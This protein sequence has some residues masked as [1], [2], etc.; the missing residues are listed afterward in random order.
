MASEIKQFAT[1]LK[2]LPRELTRDGTIAETIGDEFC[3]ELA[4]R[5]PSGL[6]ITKGGGNDEPSRVDFRKTQRSVTPFWTGNQVY[7]LEYGTGSPAVGKYP[8]SERMLESNTEYGPYAPRPLGHNLGAYWRLPDLY[9]K[10]PDTLQNGNSS[11]V[12]YYVTK[13]WEPYAPFYLTVQQFKMGAF[14]KPI[15]QRVHEIAE[16]KL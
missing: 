5:I 9:W 15:E 6:D 16:S 11:V 2:K 4:K 12:D 13:G 8:D 7:Y 1:R 3:K 10:Q 14:N